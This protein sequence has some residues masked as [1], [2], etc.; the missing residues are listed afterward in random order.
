MNFPSAGIEGGKY[1]NEIPG[2][3]WKWQFKSPSLACTREV[4][5]DCGNGAR[6]IEKAIP[7][8]VHVYN[9]NENW[10]TGVA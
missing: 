8:Q 7:D 5:H 4:A 9:Q 2:G 6:H 3:E 10:G 1:E